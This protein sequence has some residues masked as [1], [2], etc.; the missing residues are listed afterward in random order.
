MKADVFP[1]D[2]GS[3]VPECDSVAATLVTIYVIVIPALIFINTPFMMNRRDSINGSYV[4]PA[5]SSVEDVGCSMTFHQR[6]GGYS[7]K[8][9]AGVCDLL[10]KTRVLFMIKICLPYLD[11]TKNIRCPV[12]EMSLK[13]P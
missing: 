7:K 10:P 4:Q 5:E 3:H 11:L 6:G 1:E 8:N 2:L 12:N 13:L 9:W